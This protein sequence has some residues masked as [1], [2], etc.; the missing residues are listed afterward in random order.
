MYN[1][2]VIETDEA[3]SGFE[4]AVVGLAGRFPGAENV[5]QLWRNLCDGVEAISFFTDEELTAAGVAPAEL[6]DPAHVRA[7]GVLRD[8][9]L[10]DA[11]FFGF[12][13]REAEILDPQQRIFLE[14]AWAALENA[15]Y[16]PATYPGLIGVYAGM[17][18]NS[19]LY[20]NLLA[21]RT[22][23]EA[24]QP[25][26]L[27]VNSD[28]D[29]LPTR[30]C[31]KLNLRGPGVN[32]QSACS[33]S[34]VAI[35]LACQSLLNYQCDMALAGGVS[36]YPGQR[37]G[38]RFQDGGILSPDGHCRAFD[39]EAQGTVPGSGAGIVALKRLSDALADG[40]S[41]Y[42]II[43]GSAINNDGSL[44]VGYTAPSVDG[45]AEVITMAQA[46]AGVSPETISYIEAHGTGTVLGDPI[47][48]AALTQ[49][50]RL[51]TQETD[52]CAIGSV[53]S[54]VGHLD[55]A[56][57]VTSFIK[58][59]L[60]VKHGLIP[61]SLNFTRPNPK[62]DFAGSPFYVN[63]ELAQ[64][65]T[66]GVPR[67][68]GVSSFGIG[69]T[70]AHV[71][72]EEPPP[73]E[74]SCPSR[75]AQLLLL[76][77]KTLSALE[78]ATANLT[79]HLKAH[80]ELTLADAAFTLQVGR[81]PFSHRRMLVCRDLNDAL[82]ALEKRDPA[83]LFTA[84]AQAAS[85]PVVFMFTGQG[86]QYVNM[87]RGL[88]ETEPTFRAELDQC[89]DLLAPHL[90]LDLRTILFPDEDQVAA[91]TE[92]LNQTWLTQSA[93]FVIEYALAKLW[94]EWGVRP[95]AMIGHSIGEYVAACLAGV[96]SLADALTLV[97]A[98]GRLMQSLPAGSMLSLPVPEKE[99]RPLL[100]GKLSIAAV[101]TSSLCV[102][103][104]PSE[105]VDEL[106][107]KLAL[108]GIEGRRL[109][110]SHAFHSA[111]MEPILDPFVRQFSRIRLSAPSIPFISNL[112]GTWITEAEAVSPDY[113]A[114]HLRHSVR[115]ADGV[116]ELLG[117]TPH[118]FV[119]IGP[120]STLSSLVRQHA[121]FSRD[122]TV[123]SSLRHPHD[124][125]SDLGL[126]L[127]ALG[128][129]W[130]SGFSPDWKGFYTHEYRRRIPLPTYPFERKRYWIEP[131]T[132]QAGLGEARRELRKNQSVGEWFYAPSWKRAD[133]IAANV[134][135]EKKRWLVFSEDELSAHLAERLAREGHE[136][137]AVKS[138]AQFA[139]ADAHHFVINPQQPDDYL[140]LFSELAASTRLPE[141]ILYASLS[142]HSSPDQLFNP[143]FRGLLLLV[144]ALGR[145]N[146]TAPL[147]LNVLT[148]GAQEIIGDE[149]LSPERAL[150]NG[151]CRVIPQE[152]PN[153]T[154]RT[155]DLSSPT[156]NSR[157]TAQLIAE[158]TTETAYPIIA[159]RGHHRW[160]QCFEP[161]NVPREQ[162]N[163]APLRE[164]G[165]YLITG[166]L[167]R[168]G[169]T[170]AECM[171]EKVQAKLAL[172]SRTALPDKT[173]W[174]GWLETHKADDPVSRVIRRLQKIEAAGAEVLT[175]SADVTNREEMRSAMAQ[176]ESA[177]GPLSGV[178][179]SAGLVGDE[180]IRP[181]QELS[182][183]DLERQLAPKVEG[184]RTLAE[185]INGKRL[186]FCIL[187]S[188]LS[189]VL[190]GLG[191]AAYASANAFMDAFAH[192]QRQ[193]GADFWLSVN[194]DGWNFGEENSLFNATDLSMTPN[195]GGEAFAHVI[196][197]A[198]TAQ[199]AVSTGDLQLRLER[200]VKRDGAA[201]EET[202]TTAASDHSRPQLDT[203]Y[204]APRNEIENR[205]AAMWR[206]VLGI[207]EIGVHDNFFELGG[208]SLLATQLIA[209]VRDTFK[210]ELP[211]RR[212]FETPTIAGLSEMIAA[213]E[214][215]ALSAAIPAI[216]RD[217]HLPLSFAQQRLWFLDQLDPG[218]PLYN[219]PAAVR[220]SGQLNVAAMERS[221]NAIIARHEVLRTVFITE[222]GEPV[223]TI[224][225]EMKITVPVIDLT[226]LPE[227]EREAEIQRLAAE[228]AVKP[229]DLA[230]GPLLRF[231]LLRAQTEEHVALLTMHHIVSDGWSIG[232]LITELSAFYTAFVTDAEITL[233]PLTAQYADFAH[234]QR[235]SL[236]G[237]QLQRQ[238][239]YWKQK[240]GDGSVVLDL[241]TDR[242]RPAMQ[243]FRGATQ[244]LRLPEQMRNDLESLSRRQD[245]TLFM[246]LLAAFQTL[247]HR[248]TGQTDIRV[249][250]PIAG[251]TQAE[252]EN[253]IGCFINPL[254]LRAELDGELPFSSLLRQ[255]K[256]TA[257]EAYAH[258]E[259]PFEMLVEALQP[260]RDM[261]HSPLFQA[262][263]VL[264]NAP[265]RPINLP[266]LRLGEM[267][268]DRGT[269]KFDLTLF[270]EEETDGLR[271]GWSYN[272]DLFDDATI[273]RMAGHFETL[274]AGII[275]TPSERLG[276]LPLLDEHELHQT[277]IEWNDTSTHEPAAPLV[278]LAVQSQAARTPDAIAVVCGDQQ[279][280]Y[281]ELNARAN[282]LA[283]HLRR[284]G[285]G[286]ELIVGACLERSA[287]AIVALLGV[288]KAGAAWLPLDPKAPVERNA[289]ILSDA[290]ASV[291]LAQSQI[292]DVRLQNSDLQIV[293]LDADL[294]EEC[295]DNPVSAVAG[296]EL[297]YVI[298]TSGS[299]GTPKGVMVTH[300]TLA[301]HIRDARRRYEID[302]RDSVLQFASFTFDPS[303]EQIFTA[304]GC[305]AR[306]VMRA[307]EALPA[308]QFNQQIVTMGVTVMN[309]PP[310]YWQQWVQEWAKGAQLSA[311]T[312]LRMVMAG[313]DALSPE[314]LRQWQQTPMI[315]VRLLNV[316]GPTET[317][318]TATSFEIPPD[319]DV[320][321]RNRLPIGRPLPNRKLYVLDAH[322]APAPIGVPGELYI[323]GAGLARGYLNQPELTAEKFIAWQSAVGSRQSAEGNSEFRIPNS[324]F[325]LYRTGDQVRWLP[326]GNIEFIGRVDQQVKIRG[327][328]VEPGEIETALASHPAVREAI[329]QAREAK[330]GGRQLIAWVVA[331]P[332]AALT[333]AELIGHLKTKLPDYLI[334]A[335]FVMLDALPLT[336]GGKVDRRALPPPEAAALTS[337]ENHVAPRTPVEEEIARVWAQVLNLER[338]GLRDNFFE[339]GGH[340]LLATQIVSQLREKF[341]VELPLRRLF[342]APTVEGTALLIAEEQAA[343]ANDEEV[344]AL[345]AELEEMSEEE[346][347]QMLAEG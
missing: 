290:R 57:G 105:A 47:E 178:I 14:C 136:I 155:I 33:T 343:R 219:N 63:T 65:K 29:F 107:N 287:E 257:L 275:A 170:L 321:A 200:W 247:L 340:S 233:A 62:I 20:T 141:A 229:F 223:Q 206:Q 172:L 152:F 143:E 12:Y 83:R 331:Q 92:Q 28:K 21:S 213:T 72:L 76:S 216:P 188:S 32:V 273:T 246:T 54:N 11:S 111:M 334:P 17:G 18:F 140:T 131:D 142:A 196:S 332:G 161:L 267:K 158:L 148:A 314:T 300:E 127:G 96:F 150:T 333:S 82:D 116:G 224:L 245:V 171:A 297:A 319:F 295:A 15:G 209:R 194:W 91:M 108:R 22:I 145:I 266:G 313:G 298:Y 301:T 24:V 38:Y 308:A 69:G 128:K 187:Q 276:R 342:E 315:N 218:S 277:L 36:I 205:I 151:L 335:A 74:L 19:Y 220:M 302:E 121:A 26:Q 192:Q 286:P 338:V 113:W 268:P 210:V 149:N 256:E 85:K 303:L 51:G 10:F 163:S 3:F 316:Y 41:I 284:L 250:S 175:L 134:S 49:A 156:A 346:V 238:L 304:L 241:P 231:T 278:H 230:R 164:R 235:A 160:A 237:A 162:N 173:E 344:A 227:S 341:Q 270:I 115:F 293:C 1:Q 35:H 97:A 258:Q 239:D 198:Q 117:E 336:S 42:A 2:E 337:A 56:A 281:R 309:L 184:V 165:V 95:A 207:G 120:G 37:S 252:T 146:F 305:G 109:H 34:L 329:V 347:R 45:Q 9:E 94:M 186:D 154:C 122:H 299:T 318:V 174:T 177:F 70:N 312:R 147:R 204:V 345:F 84:Q 58:A 126:L 77:A 88:Y 325:R 255:V 311:P 166:G 125:Q 201:A 327:F 80:P 135:V 292:S 4:I 323:G 189:S 118:I 144:Q 253:L 71:I 279:M 99:I 265:L 215:S 211:L 280:T 217:G 242:P 228:E 262:M 326:D 59:V 114:R 81:Q 31:Y 185:I 179:H 13:P 68:A 106:E 101:N 90:N 328:R 110:T 263:L 23:R 16:D 153:L 44:K 168:I 119:E 104:G 232:V 320:A 310:A 137:I 176:I 50:F 130:L 322:G 78:T 112:S 202:E 48:L 306:L 67:R 79:E 39:A 226:A 25:Y 123:V 339:I 225:P 307:G 288:L 124:T 102:V 240:L 159:Y 100:N 260:E 285:V 53:K 249:G 181:I 259:L 129:L 208:H 73:C 254:V 283:H 203:A 214:S 60:A 52:F 43:K 139:C 221:L 330:T 243:T 212:M 234:W 180:A 199:V 98:R 27:T 64:W 5:D 55:S 86:A 291:L 296:D 289:F 190:G 61:P 6:R 7:S 261:G 133:L 30:V 66:F 274:L 248:Y 251:R 195:E 167:G 169:L 132:N 87:A 236:Q 272:T 324:E 269:E 271:L 183:R 103:S 89:A 264:Q 40:D 317:T 75:P 222:K 197:L 244:W 282:K 8:I 193:A 191:F 294:S 138:G 46:M 182:D 93:L 157:L